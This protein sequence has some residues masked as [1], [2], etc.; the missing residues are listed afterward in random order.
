MKGTMKVDVEIGIN[1]AD[2][3]AILNTLVGSNTVREHLVC[4]QDASK[5]DVVWVIVREAIARAEIRAR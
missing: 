3:E 1:E 2:V 5:Q 4:S